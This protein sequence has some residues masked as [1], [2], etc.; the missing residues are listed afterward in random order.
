MF[1]KKVLLK[2]S[3]NSQKNTCAAV[4][5]LRPA[6]LVKKETPKQ[7]FFCEIFRNFKEHIFYKT[8]LSV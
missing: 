8:P 5:F 2:I 3:Q 4:S 6:T 7:V 1:L